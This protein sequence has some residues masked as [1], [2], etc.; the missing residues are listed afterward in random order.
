MSSPTINQEAAFEVA[1]VEA[2]GGPSGAGAAFDRLE[3]RMKTLRGRKMYGVLYPG[4]PERYFACLRLDDAT[5]DDLGFE[6]AS[7][8]GGLYGRR[9]IRGW[10][11]KLPELPHFFDTLRAELVDTGYVHDRERP[12]IEYYRRVDELIIMVPVLPSAAV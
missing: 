11:S 1:R 7:V 2:V 5:S 3:G 9:L 6:R 12:S 4:N 8:P 10:D